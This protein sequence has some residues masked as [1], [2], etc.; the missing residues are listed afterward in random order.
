MTIHVVGDSHGNVF[1]GLAGFTFA[2]EPVC[3]YNLIDPE[4][5]NLLNSAINTPKG[6]HVL[7]IFGEIDCRLHIHIQNRPIS[8]SIDN[9][10]Q[11][12]GSVGKI[13]SDAGVDFAFYNVVP[14]GTWGNLSCEIGLRK[15]IYRE[16][17][18]KL[19]LYCR[20]NGYKIVDVWDLVAG[21]DGFAKP[22]YK[23]DEVHLNTKAL[24]ILLKEIKRV[25]P[26]HM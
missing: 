25:F 5:K 10:I 20:E 2:Q 17:H 23:Q 24:P 11:R 14:T 15:R 1:W 16:F 22:E 12:Y 6:D 19:A 26:L 9:T 13:L 3:A 18:D 4:H 7:L 21:E 8:D